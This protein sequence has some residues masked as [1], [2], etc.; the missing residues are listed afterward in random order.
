M[1]NFLLTFCL[2]AT[3]ATSRAQTNYACTIT[4]SGG[5][6][7]YGVGPSITVSSNY[8][9]SGSGIADG[10]YAWNGSYWI[11]AGSPYNPQLNQNGTS[12]TL[13]GTNGT[14][15]CTSSLGTF[16]APPDSPQVWTGSGWTGGGGVLPWTVIRS[17]GVDVVTFTSTNATTGWQPVAT[18]HFS[19]PGTQ[20][21]QFFRAVLTITPPQ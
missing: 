19:I 21:Q 10:N 18:N 17:V 13:T 15:V 9:V 3:V 4:G 2:L 1:K 11:I 20:P 14:P 5:T 16:T 7:T 6:F 8:V 12:W